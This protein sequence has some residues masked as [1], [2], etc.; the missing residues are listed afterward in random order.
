MKFD[1]AKVSTLDQIKPGD[2]LRARGT[3]NPD[4]T[5]VAAAEI[6]TGAF[7]NLSGLISSIDTAANTLSLNDLATKKPVVVKISPDSQIRK[8]SPQMAQMLARNAGGGRGGAAAGGA[9]DGGNAGGAPTDGGRGGRGFGG[10]GGGGDI[11][12]VLSRL[13]ASTLADLQKGDAVMIV[14]TEGTTSDG[15]TAI[16]VLGGVEPLLTANGSQSMALPPWS[17]GGGGGDA[18]GPE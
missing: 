11:Q 13:P 10:R 7:R 3:K 15:V 12:Q 9:P 18:G 8:L 6:V 5:Q 16:T 4:G 14:S 17:V 1:D 2:Q